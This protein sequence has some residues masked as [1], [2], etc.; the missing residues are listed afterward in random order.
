[1]TA[2]RTPPPK[3]PVTL[4]AR[5]AFMLYMK[6]W[7]ELL[8]LMDWRISLSTKPAKK[9]NMAEVGRHYE[10][11][12]AVIYLGEDF[13]PVSVDDDSLSEIALHEALHILL[14]ELLE[15]R[16]DDEVP[17]DVV[18]SIEHRVIHILVGLLAG[19]GH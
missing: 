18:A 16:R 9:T 10:A 19:K 4:P 5:E 3:N 6:H 14:Y 17:E 15:V 7:Q 12:L 13:G 11:R 2:R 8:G 1:V